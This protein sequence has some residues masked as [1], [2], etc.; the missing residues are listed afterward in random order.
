MDHSPTPSL[1]AQLAE[2]RRAVEPYIFFTAVLLAVA[3]A[4]VLVT[5]EAYSPVGPRTAS[6][7]AEAH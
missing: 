1:C 3:L 2:R 7:G 5:R 6:A 4:I